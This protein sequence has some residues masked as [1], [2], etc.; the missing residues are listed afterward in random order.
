MPHAAVE[1][2]RYY[3]VGHDSRPALWHH[4]WIGTKTLE[5][6]CEDVAAALRGGVAVAVHRR[7]RDSRAVVGAGLAV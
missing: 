3:L 5:N 2:Y 1:P 7:V 4:R 6:A